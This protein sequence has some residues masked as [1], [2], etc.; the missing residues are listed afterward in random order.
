MENTRRIKKVICIETTGDTRASV[1]ICG[2]PPITHKPPSSIHVV[3]VDEDKIEEVSK[4][5]IPGLSLK[6]HYVK[7][8]LGKKY[9]DTKFK[10]EL[11]WECPFAELNGECLAENMDIDRTLSDEEQ[12]AINKCPVHGELLLRKV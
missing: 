12:L 10:C 3:I 8:N 7:Q 11:C 9:Y 6:V 1:S 4:M 2:G 5:D